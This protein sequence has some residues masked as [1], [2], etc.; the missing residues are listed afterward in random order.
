M[1]ELILFVWWLATVRKV[2]RHQMNM[3]QDHWVLLNVHIWFQLHH[4]D[5][6]SCRIMAHS[7]MLRILDRIL[8]VASNGACGIHSHIKTCRWRWKPSFICYRNM[9]TGLNTSWTSSVVSTSL[10][11]PKIYYYVVSMLDNLSMGVRMKAIELNQHVYFVE[12]TRDHIFFVCPYS[13]HVCT[14]VCERLFGSDI[15]TAPIWSSRLISRAIPPLIYK[16]S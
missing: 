13:L 2:D 7:D 1:G 10:V 3:V 4:L 11:F 9:E 16:P 8:F 14:S 6:T 15:Y 5:W 12:K